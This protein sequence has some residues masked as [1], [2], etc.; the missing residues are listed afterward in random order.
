MTGMNPSVT[1]GYEGAPLCWC[2]AFDC[3]FYPITVEARCGKDRRGLA[4]LGL[5]RHGKVSHLKN[6]SAGLLVAGLHMSIGLLPRLRLHDWH[7]P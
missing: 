7:T 2:L 6:V 3:L 1:A 5:V 4:R